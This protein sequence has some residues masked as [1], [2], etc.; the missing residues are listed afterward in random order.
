MTTEFDHLKAMV[1]KYCILMDQVDALD[2]ERGELRSKCIEVANNLIS[3]GIDDPRKFARVLKGKQPR[4]AKSE[5]T[6]DAE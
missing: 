5:R 4:V 6:D 2:A 3:Y 1:D